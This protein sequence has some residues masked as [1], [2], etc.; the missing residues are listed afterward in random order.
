MIHQSLKLTP[1]LVE[2]IIR[3]FGGIQ[4]SRLSSLSLLLSCTLGQLNRM[5]TE[6]KVSGKLM[7]SENII[8]A[9]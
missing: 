7:E 9:L 3:R 4:R 1:Q 2:N 5:I 8:T 6:L